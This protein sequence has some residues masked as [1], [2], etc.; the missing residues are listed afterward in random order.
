MFDCDYYFFPSAILIYSQLIQWCNWNANREIP[1]FLYNEMDSS[2]LVNSNG[3]L[4]M[5]L[6]ALPLQLIQIAHEEFD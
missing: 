3:L 4:P 5:L 1:F 2:E 6:E